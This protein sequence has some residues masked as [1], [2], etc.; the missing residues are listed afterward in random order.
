LRCVIA[1][2]RADGGVRD[3]EIDRDGLIV[4]RTVRGIAMVLKLQITDFLGLAVTRKDGAYHVALAHRDPSLC[5]PLAIDGNAAACAATCEAWTAALSLPLIEDRPLVAD[6]ASPRR[7][8]RNVIR[9]RRPTYPLRRITS[10][11]IDAMTVHRDEREI[12]ARN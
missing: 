9:T 4:R 7:R 10:R 2:A 8:R 11:V 1:D 3:V 6:A 5:V 12:I